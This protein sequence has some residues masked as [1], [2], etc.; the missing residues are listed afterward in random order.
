MKRG[1]RAALVAGAVNL[2]VLVGCTQEP[3]IVR[4]DG[5]YL[6]NDAAK[7]F[8]ADPAQFK[9]AIQS[10]DVEAKKAVPARD[11]F[12]GSA[13][14]VLGET[15][16]IPQAILARGYD[17]E[18]PYLLPVEGNFRDWAEAY[19]GALDACGTNEAIMERKGYDLAG[20]AVLCGGRV[21][22]E[23]LR[24][25]AKRGIRGSQ[26]FESTAFYAQI[27]NSAYRAGMQPH[28]YDEYDGLL[29]EVP[30]MSDSELRLALFERGVSGKVY[31][32]YPE[33]HR[34]DPEGIITL[35]DQGILGPEAAEWGGCLSPWDIQ[36]L[37]EGG[38]DKERSRELCLIAE[39]FDAS[40]S[41]ADMLWFEEQGI[42]VDRVREI[43]QNQYKTLEEN[44]IRNR[45]Q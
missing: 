40:I 21:P 33:H 5:E 44:A 9:S 10:Y 39:E 8:L 19:M 31:A 18:E 6:L 16:A 11:A 43:A 1:I 37:D 14:P 3:A 42:P 13:R 23:Y 22:L 36:A 41:G 30:G 38:Y 32:E 28:D 20:R 26:G 7:E 29:V 17:P 27:V 34:N 2:A 45:L 15:D 25:F 35:H 4:E 12:G 24:E